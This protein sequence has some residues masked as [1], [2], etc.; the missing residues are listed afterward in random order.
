MNKKVSQ[1]DVLVVLGLDVDKKPHAAAFSTAD[2]QTVRKA[3][4]LMG[5]RV[6]YANDDKARTAARKLPKGKL[7]ATGKALVPLVRRAIFED[8]VETLSFDGPTKAAA[9]GDASAG[10]SPSQGSQPHTSPPAKQGGADLW[11][12]IK[13]GS[14]VLCRDDGDEPGWWESVV[15]AIGPDNESMTVRWRDYPD[16][17]SFPAKRHAVALLGPQAPSKPARR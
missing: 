9:S 7:F 15:M 14:V 4:G 13:V 8:L 12:D 16:F 10:N 3:A 5:M 2:E 11:A 1:S 17:K 6:G